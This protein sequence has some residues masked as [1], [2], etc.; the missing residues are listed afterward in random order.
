MMPMRGIFATGCC[1]RAVSG[2]TAAA[3]P[4]SVLKSRRLM[5]RPLADDCTLPHC[6]VKAVL[7]I[8]A[9]LAT[10]LP[11]WVIHDIAAIPACPVRPKSGHS[12]E[13]KSPNPDLMYTDLSRT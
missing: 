7:C 13:E 8:T 9:I 4:R 11:Q 2:H 10:R 1:A 3:L 5:G 6:G 12:T